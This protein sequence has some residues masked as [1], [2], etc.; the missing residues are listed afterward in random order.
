MPNINLIN[1]N[2]LFFCVMLLLCPQA[3]LANDNLARLMETRYCSFC[4]FRHIQIRYS[5]NDL[6]APPP[7]V[8]LTETYLVHADFSQADLTNVNFAKSYLNGARF[9]EA[10][11]SG[12]N[13]SGSELELAD[14][15]GADL[16]NAVFFQAYLLHARISVKQLRTVKLCQTTLPNASISH[17]DCN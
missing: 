15:F 3:G 11:L 4:D 8:D 1:T 17:R 10:N 5:T 14:F 12:A 2:H 7:V 6:I 16:T 9:V 13:F